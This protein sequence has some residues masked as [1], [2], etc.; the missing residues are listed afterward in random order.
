MYKTINAAF[1]WETCFS[2]PLSL[3][4]SLSPCLPPSL[5]LSLPPSLPLSLPCLPQMT[6]AV[7]YALFLDSYNYGVED[8]AADTGLVCCTFLIQVGN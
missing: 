6:D 4:P 7:R 5:P 8:R 3:P 2:L 1:M